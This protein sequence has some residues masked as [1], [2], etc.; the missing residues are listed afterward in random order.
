MAAED[1][2]IAKLLF[3]ERTRKILH[4][5]SKES[6]STKEIA[7]KIGERPLNLYHTINKLLE[8][9]FIQVDKEV[10][11]NNMMERYYSSRHIMDTDLS[12]E[13]DFVKNHYDVLVKAVMLE[14]NKAI[15]QLQNDIER[16]ESNPGEEPKS[17]AVFSIIE[18]KLNEQNWKKLNQQIGDFEDDPDGDTYRFVVAAYKD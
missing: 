3:N 6:L 9:G 13:G 2:S 18:K 5:L 4:E 12:Y 8:Y 1:T 7:K 10:R 17:T 11:V 16:T 15:Y 14:V